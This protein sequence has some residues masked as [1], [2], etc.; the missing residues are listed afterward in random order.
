MELLLIL[1]YAAICVAV[2][3]IGGSGCGLYAICPSLRHHQANPSPHAEL[4]ELRV[5]GGPLILRWINVLSSL[6]H[7]VRIEL[8]H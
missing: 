4:G 1:T 7:N 6:T 5:P 2:F 3:K 8:V